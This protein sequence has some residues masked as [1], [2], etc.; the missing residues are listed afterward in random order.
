MVIN[1]KNEKR[2]WYRREKEEVKVKDV[3]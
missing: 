3:E 2:G 1:E